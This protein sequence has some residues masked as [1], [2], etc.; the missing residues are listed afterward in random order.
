MV[1]VELRRVRLA[2][3]RKMEKRKCGEGE[4]GVFVL[5]LLLTVQEK[6]LNKII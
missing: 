6:K 3:E 1:S 4:G 5:L 2:R